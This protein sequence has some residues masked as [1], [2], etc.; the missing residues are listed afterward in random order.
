MKTQQVNTVFGIILKGVATICILLITFFYWQN[1]DSGKYLDIEYQSTVFNT[2]TGK[3][4]INKDYWAT[5]DSLKQMRKSN[6]S[7]STNVWKP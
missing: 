2:Q 1:K 4:I 6:H 5:A 3:Y 7:P